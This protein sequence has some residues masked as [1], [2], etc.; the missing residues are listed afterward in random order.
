MGGPPYLPLSLLLY[1]SAVAFCKSLAAQPPSRI[2]SFANAVAVSLRKRLFLRPVC[3]THTIRNPRLLSPMLH[4]TRRKPLATVRTFHKVKI[5]PAY[6]LGRNRIAAL[7][8]WMVERGQDFLAVD[9]L[10]GHH[11]LHRTYVAFCSL[12]PKG[13]GC[14]KA[15][16]QVYTLDMLGTHG[17]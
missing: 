7:R 3:T 17:I 16:P 6:F 1:S 4:I 10:S 14:A 13:F 5:N 12:L 15:E 2:I 8:A 9:F 11:P